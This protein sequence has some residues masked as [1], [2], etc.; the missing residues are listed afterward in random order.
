MSDEEKFVRCCFGPFNEPVD[1]VGGKITAKKLDN[2]SYDVAITK[3]FYMLNYREAKTMEEVKRLAHPKETSREWGNYTQEHLQKLAEFLP[4][5][6]EG[7]QDVL[8]LLSANQAPKEEIVICRCNHEVPSKS[9]CRCI[10]L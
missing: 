3:V 2:G 5:F 1:L 8:A 9:C 7:K 10:I 6:F 4:L